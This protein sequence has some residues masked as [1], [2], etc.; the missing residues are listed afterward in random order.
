MITTLVWKRFYIVVSIK[1][2]LAVTEWIVLL[3]AGTVLHHEYQLFRLFRV[4]RLVKLLSRWGHRTL[5]WTFIK[6]FQYEKASIINSLTGSN[7]YINWRTRGDSRHTFFGTT[8]VFNTCSFWKCRQSFITQSLFKIRISVSAT[9]LQFGVQSMESHITYRTGNV[10]W[11]Q[12]VWLPVQWS[13]Y[14]Q[15]YASAVNV[16]ATYQNLLCVCILIPSPHH[17]LLWWTDGCLLHNQTSVSAH[18][19]IASVLCRSAKKTQL[20]LMPATGGST[21]HACA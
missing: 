5:L 12:P 1:V 15:H 4:M 9:I 8:S 3:T 7:G 20:K 18:G 10:M 6:S 11:I 19:S 17:R 21:V 13:T 14:S 2:R 16:N